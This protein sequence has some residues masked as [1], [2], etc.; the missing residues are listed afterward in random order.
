MLTESFG[1]MS[2]MSDCDEAC[3]T[4][5]PT[6]QHAEQKSDFV[7]DDPTTMGGQRRGAILRVMWISES[8]NEHP[9]VGDFVK[10]LS[11][12]A[13]GGL[14]VDNIRTGER[15]Y[16]RWEV[17]FPVPYSK[18]CKCTTSWCRCIY[19]SYEDFMVYQVINPRVRR[20]WLLL[21]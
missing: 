8:I 2:V 10:V 20:P 5:S 18:L 4:P 11:F 1:N 7:A 15:C 21:T 14:D 3:S 9:F 17:M 6:V 13:T 12:S 16:I 19:E